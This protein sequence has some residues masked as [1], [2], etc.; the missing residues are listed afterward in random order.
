[1]ARRLAIAQAIVNDPMILIIDEPTAGLDP[2]ERMRFRHLLSTLGT[3]R[4]VLFSTHIVDDIEQTCEYIMILNRVLLYAG[5]IEKLLETLDNAQVVWTVVASSP[6]ED[7]PD[8]TIVRYMPKAGQHH[9]HI[10]SSTQPTP[11]AVPA[12]G[13]LEEGY[14]W[15]IQKHNYTQAH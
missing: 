5:T 8:W 10:V 13:S 9:Y 1:M 3:Q 14:A 12:P 6:L 2:E 7:R 15:I 4:T 11:N